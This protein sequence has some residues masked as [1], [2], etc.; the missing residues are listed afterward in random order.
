LPTPDKRRFGPPPDARGE[1]TLF[2]NLWPGTAKN[3]QV[4][5]QGRGVFLHFEASTHGRIA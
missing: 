1:Q 4:L 3:Q 5:Q 2:G